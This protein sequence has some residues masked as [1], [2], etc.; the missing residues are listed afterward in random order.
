MIRV[1]KRIADRMLN[2]LVPASDASACVDVCVDRQCA[3]GQWM[4][5]S[6]CAMHLCCPGG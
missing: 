1:A 2:K 6:P 5:C 4:C 3:N